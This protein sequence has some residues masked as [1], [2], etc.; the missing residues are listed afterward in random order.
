MAQ[1]KRQQAILSLFKDFKGI[2]PLKEL[3]WAELNYERVNQPLSMRDWKY[4]VT[5]LLTDGPLLFAAGGDNAFVVI[6]ARFAADSLLLTHERPIVTKLLREHPYALFVFSN[7]DQDRWHFINVKHDEDVEKRRI[8]RRITIGPEERLRTASERI[9]LL[10]LALIDTNLF[11]ISPLAI[12]RR[13]D[14]AFDVEAV[15]KQFFDEYQAVFNILQKDLERQTKDKQ[16]AHDYALQFLNRCMFLYF[17]QRKGWL[18]GDREFLRTFWETYNDSSQPPDTFVDKWLKVMFFEAFNGKPIGAHRHLPDNIR[19]V[20]ALAPFLNGGLFSENNLDKRPGFVISDNRFKQVFTF[21][22]RYNFT[23]AEDS[24]LD[25][26]VAVDPEMIGK[27]YESLVNVSEETSER[28]DAGIFYTPRIEITLMCRLALVD[29][30]ANHLGE[31]YKSLLYELIFA[32]EPDEKSIVDKKCTDAKLW[33]TLDT[34]FRKIT[35]LDPACGSGSFLVGMLYLLN[36]LRERTNKQL[37]KHENSYELK[38]Q[39]IGESLYGV[40][41]M[42]W[43]CHVAE[44]RLWLAL[45]ADAEFTSHDLHIRREPLLPH[46]SFKVRQGDSL[47]QEVGGINFSHKHEKHE[48]IPALK[49]RIT[50]LKTEKLKFYNNDPDCRYKTVEALN[51]EELQLFQ[52]MLDSREQKLQEQIKDLRRKIEGQHNVMLDGTVVQ[53]PT[54]MGLEVVGWQK[55]KDALTRELDQVNQ[56]RSILK[57]VKDIPFVW[58]IAFVEIFEGDKEGF[59]IVIGN[60]PYVR[61][62]KISDP[63]LSGEESTTEN[64]KTYK[65]KLINSVYQSF[66]RFF[67]YN[68]KDNSVSKKLDAKSDLYIYFYFHGLSLLN[69][70]GSFCFITSNSWLDVG[71]GKDLQEFLLKH[72]HVKMVLDNQVK[73][74][75][76]S[77]DVNTVIVLFSSPDD[78]RMWATDK[79]ARFVMFKVPF[80]HVLSPVI[81]E[82]IEESDERAQTK[83]YRLFP[84]KQEQL[85]KDGCEQGEEDEETKDEGRGTKDIIVRDKK[86]SGLLIK[87]AKYIGNKWGGKYL[88]APDIYWT[89]LEK[90]K[91]KLV[92]LGDI[93]EVRRGF[94]TGANEFFYLDEAKIRHWGIGEEFLKPVIKSPRECKRILIDPKDLKYKIFMC[95]KDKKD[96]KGTSSL[97]YIKWGEAQGFH[98]R[99]SCVGRTRWWEARIENA[100]GIFVKEANTTSAVFYNPGNLPVDCRLY[101]SGLSLQKILFL[102]SPIAAMFFEIYNRAGLG[103]GARSLMVSDYNDVP[104]LKDDSV[105]IK[106]DSVFNH[107]IMSSPRN[108]QNPRSDILKDMDSIIFDALNLTQTERDAVYEAVINLVESRLKKAGSV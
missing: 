24:P 28:G 26:E 66:P 41:V 42:D 22:E 71:Y 94:T 92:R 98:E 25:Q 104:C 39:I 84:I 12:Q 16:W 37:G 108:L 78:K 95:H 13:H 106:S 97:E 32:I 70:K 49:G 93:A 87:S 101:C 3:F 75:F 83:E 63:T 31:Q 40:D 14:E 62:E 8:F 51:H 11:G 2:E 5:N 56:S 99:P 9:A 15:T 65:T 53:K 20:L 29:H 30:L 43:A 45:I 38:K 47:V 48:I 89:I 58:D 100:S 77:A 54:Q 59:D 69:K 46:F 27:V 81:F 103:E 6:Y 61:Q 19:N 60:P 50:K 18:G 36:D 10:D 76:A 79:T 88:R 33:D 44:L 35:I 64:R 68:A 23:I 34:L 82:E 86:S 4:T 74:S 85:L 7:A 91:G 105:F 80:E 1:E 67:G 57:T 73:R 107:I 55:E 21:L 17:I 90:G 52:N 72:S 102:N 96:L